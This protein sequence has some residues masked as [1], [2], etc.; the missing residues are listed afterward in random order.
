MNAGRMECEKE[1]F[2]AP[3]ERAATQLTAPQGTK[4]HMVAEEQR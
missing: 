4:R 2:G 3:L 1:L